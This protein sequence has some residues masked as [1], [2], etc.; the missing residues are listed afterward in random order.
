MG[1]NKLYFILGLICL[2]GYVW[3]FFS[4]SNQFQNSGFGVCAFKRIT[5]IPC[6]SCG[7]T[8]AL[9]LL[10]QGE[11]IGSILLNPFGILSAILL[12]IVPMWLFYDLISKKQTLFDF[13]KKAE[14]II[15]IR[16]IAITLICIVVANWIWNIQKNL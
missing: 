2:T 11:F 3:L 14:E 9:L 16:W 7:S 13:Y 5:S 8:R 12:L 10:L 1:R 15:R 4:M 6:P